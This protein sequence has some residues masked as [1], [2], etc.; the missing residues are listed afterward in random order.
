MACG[1]GVQGISDKVPEKEV[2]PALDTTFYGG[3]LKPG[4]WVERCSGCG[5][6]VLN[7]TGDICPIVR[8]SKSLLNGP[9]GGSEG[10]KCEVSKDIDCAWQLIY[11]RLKLRG[12]LDTLEEIVPIRDWRSAG[13]GGF[14]KNGS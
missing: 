7:K 3:L 1:V 13:H 5:T 4:V 8:C 11:D 10:G 14:K 2:L 12:K 9:C 6:C